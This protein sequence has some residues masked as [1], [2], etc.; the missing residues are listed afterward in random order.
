MYYRS[1]SHAR[2]LSERLWAV[3]PGVLLMTLLV[4][5]SLLA[6]IALMR[7]GVQIW[8]VEAESAPATI[9]VVEIAPV[10]AL[11]VLLLALTV[12]AQAPLGY[13]QRTAAQLH[14]SSNYAS[15]VLAP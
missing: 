14:T 5:S 11:L 15:A 9:R 2:E 6:L 12:L 4:S 3:W 1:F 8:W 13:A 7:S 10:A